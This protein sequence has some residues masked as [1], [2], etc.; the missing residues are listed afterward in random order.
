MREC[1]VQIFGLGPGGIGVAVAADTL[2]VLPK[3]LSLGAIWFDPFPYR[4]E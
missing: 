4:G 2:G 3:L 1:Y